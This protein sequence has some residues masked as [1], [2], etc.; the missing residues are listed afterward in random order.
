[1]SDILRI[2]RDK[3]E[4]DTLLAHSSFTMTQEAK[5]PVDQAFH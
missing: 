5:S 3:I 1:M 2:I 4:F